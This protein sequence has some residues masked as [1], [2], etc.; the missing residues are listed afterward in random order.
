MH[1]GS[2]VVFFVGYLIY[3]WILVIRLYTKTRA[4]VVQ[5]STPSLLLK[6]VCALVALVSLVLLATWSQHWGENATRIAE[7]SQQCDVHCFWL[8]IQQFFSLARPSQMEWLATFSIQG[9]NLSCYAEYGPTYDVAT[10]FD[11]TLKSRPFRHVAYKSLPFR[12]SS[13]SSQK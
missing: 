11:T 6:A 9:F 8:C 7:V 1:S 10:V 5:V 12:A 2:A 13:E 3:M 4:R